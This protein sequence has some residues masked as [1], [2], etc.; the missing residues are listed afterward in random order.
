MS[1][2][3]YLGKPKFVKVFKLLNNPKKKFRII[4]QERKA[5]GNKLERARSFTLHDLTGNSTID[6]VKKRLFK[7]VKR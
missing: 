1:E 7:G 3:V 5:N 6:S 4:I 2:I